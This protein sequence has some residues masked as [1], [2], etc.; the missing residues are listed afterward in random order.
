MKKYGIFF[1]ILILSSSCHPLKSHLKIK[2]GSW[3]SGPFLGGHET[4]TRF[5]IRFGNSLLK[6]R[7]GLQNYYPEV[8]EPGR[9]HPLIEGNIKT[10][11]PNEALFDF[12]KMEKKEF[13]A[14]H[15]SSLL[16]YIH[17]MRNFSH[18]GPQSF[19]ESCQKIKDNILN[20]TLWSLS[21]FQKGE[22]EE[23]LFWLGHAIHILQDSFSKA[24]T[25]R[26][27]PFFKKILDICTYGEKFNSICFHKKYKDIFDGDRIWKKE[28]NCH[29]NPFER[30]FFCLKDEAQAAVS[31]TAGYLFTVGL[32]IEEKVFS[33]FEVKKEIR[34]FLE[35]D[36]GEFR[37]Y[38]DCRD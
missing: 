29:L 24:H 27:G 4:I 26:G 17:S 21:F 37:G 1:S 9:G 15:Q 6:E 33:P 38:F 36:E 28:L 35:V 3:T 25:L 10:D 19:L 14:W 7:Y 5:A 8:S 23:G 11:F 34:D 16:Q 20:V 31:A 22:R 2:E 13:G 30:T 12:Y 18:R 32:L